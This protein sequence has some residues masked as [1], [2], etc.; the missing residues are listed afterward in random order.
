M[1]KKILKK[2][3]LTLLLLTISPI[4][5]WIL[6]YILNIIFNCQIQDEGGASICVEGISDIVYSF[7]ISPWL[8][9]I[10]L[11]FFGIPTLIIGIIW[12]IKITGI[13]S[14]K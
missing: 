11:P 6:G 2:S 10:T 14:K 8:L 9:M 7:L 5:L 1:R 3:F 12:L 4:L 13:F